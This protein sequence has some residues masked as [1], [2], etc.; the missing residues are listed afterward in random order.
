MVV[1]DGWQAFPSPPPPHPSPFPFPSPSQ[2]AV[3]AYGSKCGSGK[4]EKALLLYMPALFTLQ[5]AS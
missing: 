3:A 2:V 5:H 4:P 1:E